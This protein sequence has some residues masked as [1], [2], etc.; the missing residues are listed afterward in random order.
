MLM[1]TSCCC[2]CIIVEHFTTQVTNPASFL[3]LPTYL[4]VI[5]WP[6]LTNFRNLIW[7]RKIPTKNYLLLVVLEYSVN[8][9]SYMSLSFKTEMPVYLILKS[10]NLLASMI[11]SKLWFKRTYPPYKYIAATMVSAGVFLAAQTSG[12][13]AILKNNQSLLEWSEGVAIVT[14]CLFGAVILGVL[15]EQA[16]YDFGKRKDELVFYTHLFGLPGFIIVK[17]SIFKTISE[18]NTSNK[19]IYLYIPYFWVLLGIFLVMSI[20]CIHGIYHLL[21]EWSSLSVTM[22]MTICKFLSL[23]LSIYIFEYPVT[24][25]LSFAVFMVDSTAIT[26]P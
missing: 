16:Y 11:V 3:T 21:S 4:A 17:D 26:G 5:T 19:I 12:N 20:A 15:Q 10:G 13:T 23:L 9:Y 14:H 18:V 8:L 7:N 24:Y 25:T 1:L 22:V 6:V 2:T